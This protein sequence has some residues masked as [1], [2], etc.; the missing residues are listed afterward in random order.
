MTR[1]KRTKEEASPNSMS[2][3]PDKLHKMASNTSA[4]T[5]PAPHDTSSGPGPYFPPHLQFIASQL[6]PTQSCQYPYPSPATP[7]S[8]RTA[9]SPVGR[10]LNQVPPPQIDA[11]MIHSILVSLHSIEEGQ[12]NIQLKLNKLDKIEIDVQTISCKV[13]QV[14][15]KVITL[16]LKL[17]NTETKLS[18]L[19]TS[20]TFDS[21][22]YDD[23]RATQQ[24]LL[25]SIKNLKSENS[26][27]SENLLDLQARS[28]RD[29]L[30]FFNFEEEKSFEARKSEN[31]L[32]KIHQFCEQ[33]LHIDNPVDTIKI[34]RA[35]RVGHF[36]QGKNRPIVVKFNFY[37]DK[38]EIKNKIFL[39][40]TVQ[41]KRL[42]QLSKQLNRHD[43]VLFH[44]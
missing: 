25:Q 3:Q 8:G 27:L 39:N 17:T 23:V 37:G 1:K 34:D 2:G 38:L 42:E 36:E 9:Y 19:E 41:L 4:P 6:T 5:T 35:H 40:N 32:N 15:A 43:Q 30:L 31:C 21:E 26:Q 11:N 44:L 12:R 10:Q 13:T 29:N 14:E 33:Q 18:D 28:M 16:E 7:H 24:D 20:R 22:V